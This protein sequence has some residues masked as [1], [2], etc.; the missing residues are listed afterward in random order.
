MK[1]LLITFPIFAL[2]F[3]AGCNKNSSTPAVPTIVDLPSGGLANFN[4]ALLNLTTDTVTV[5]FTAE[6]SSGFTLS[7]NLIVTVAPDDSKR[8][9]YN[10]DG[11]IIQ[12]DAMPAGS[13]TIPATYDTIKPGFTAVTFSVLFYRSKIDPTKN[14]MLPVSITGATGATID[15]TYTSIYYH[16]IGNPLSGLYSNTGTRTSY[17]G[18]VTAGIVASVDSCPSPKLISPESGL[19]SDCDYADLGPSGWKYKIT[20]EGGPTVVVAPNDI[21]AASI[22]AFKDLGSTY[23]EVNKILHLKT[24]YTNTVGDDRVVDELLKRQ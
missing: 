20:W 22:S 1:K 2:I 17:T 23:D 6:I 3:A 21:M 9:A 7:N 13:Y 5:Y 11:S 19:L 14:F 15:S 4:A 16:T 18:P 10:S 12:Y 24:Q 8:T